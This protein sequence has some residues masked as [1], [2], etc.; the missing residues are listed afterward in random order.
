MEKMRVEKFEESLCEDCERVNLIFLQ[1]FSLNLLSRSSR[2]FVGIRDIYIRVR[3]ECEESGFSKQSW[4]A[5]W[6]RD[7][8]ESQVQ[9]ASKQN[10]Q[11]GL[12]VLQCFNWR[13]CSSSLHAS[14]VCII[15]RLTS[16]EP[17]ASSSRE[18]LLL[19]TN[20]SISSHSLT[21]YLYMILT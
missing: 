10:C 15:W 17:P 6:P 5:T 16:C 12:F 2:Y 1:G 13:D 4:L 8:T 19:C 9:A 7:L 11:T 20:L 14:L 3:M 21:H 18:S